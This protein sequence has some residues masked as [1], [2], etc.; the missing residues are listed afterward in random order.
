[1][2]TALHNLFLFIYSLFND[3]FSISDNI[4]S[5]ERMIV[6]WIGKDVEG[7]GNGLIQ[8]TILAFACRDWGKH[9]NLSQDSR[10]LGRDLNPGPP[11]YEAGVL[12]TL[13]WRIA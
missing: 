1:M 11:E 9:E 4:A 6:F 10:S 7:S 12:T 2:A 3:A 8:D 13:P 5:N